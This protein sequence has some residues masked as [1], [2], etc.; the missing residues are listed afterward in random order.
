MTDTKRADGLTYGYNYKNETL[1]LDLAITNEEQR[2]MRCIITKEDVKLRDIQRHKEARR[3]K[4]TGLTERDQKKLDIEG[5][6]SEMIRKGY[7]KAEIRKALNFTRQKLYYY[8]YLFEQQEVQFINP[9]EDA[10]EEVK[11]LRVI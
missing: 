7:S 11:K 6:V 1:I 4:T 2:D 9:F 8:N 10:K 5:K 3:D